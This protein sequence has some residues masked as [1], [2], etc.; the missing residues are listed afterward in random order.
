MINRQ[1]CQRKFAA[2]CFLA[3]VAAV[4]SLRAQR[5]SHPAPNVV[6]ILM[7]DMGYADIGSY[8]VK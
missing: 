3:I 4:P 8:G 5:S 7:D 6:M 1:G 2:I